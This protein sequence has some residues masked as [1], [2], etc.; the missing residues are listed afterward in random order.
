MTLAK[1]HDVR[2]RHILWQEIPEPQSL[3]MALRPGAVHITAEAMYR[4]NATQMLSDIIR[5]FGGEFYIT[6]P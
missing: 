3:R 2:S 6:L 1:A 5:A 4:N